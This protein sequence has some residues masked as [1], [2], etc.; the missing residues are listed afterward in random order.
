MRPAVRRSNRKS[1]T[2]RLKVTFVTIVAAGLSL[3]VASVAEAAWTSAPT[4]VG[5]A[6][7]GMLAA[8]G[9]G[10]T[11]S[12]TPSSL[13]I[14]WGAASG[15]PASGGYM[16]FR[17]TLGTTI[18]SGSNGI[19]VNSF[20]G[21]GTLNVASTTGFASPSG[22]VEVTT[23]TGGATLSYTGTTATAFTGVATTS[24]SGTLSTT[25]SVIQ[26]TQITA[27]GNSCKYPAASPC[28]DSGLSSS[29]TYYYVVESAIQNWSSASNAPFSGTT[30]SAASVTVSSVLNQ[31][32][33]GNFLISGGVVGGGSVS[34]TVWSSFTTGTCTAGTLVG[35]VTTTL[36][37]T[38]WSGSPAKSALADGTIYW[39]RATETGPSA[40]S[41]VYSFMAPAKNG[42]VT[43][44]TT[45]C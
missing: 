9:T 32:D 8:P 42:S 27:A 30:S 39:I 11:G 16:L 18:A 35:T 43:P 23:S 38:T 13:S 22:H 7:A 28:T 37:G 4:G 1:G 34:F 15:L 12:A 24:G 21:S 31:G 20:A 45:G 25:S 26:G 29:T 3:S 44:T 10:S 40:T 36:N 2:L 5:A 19:N 14:S 41:P 6:E 17:S 33:S